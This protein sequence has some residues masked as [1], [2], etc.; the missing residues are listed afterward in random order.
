ML[1]VDHL[2]CYGKRLAARRLQLGPV[3][4]RGPSLPPD[5]ANLATLDFWSNTLE[6]LPE[7]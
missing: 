6:P 5:P 7:N 1:T 4:D 3:Y 2:L